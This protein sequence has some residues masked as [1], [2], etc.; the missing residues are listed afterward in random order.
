MSTRRKT[1]GEDVLGET[2]LADIADPYT[3][4]GVRARFSDL[5]IRYE[6]HS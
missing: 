5:S 3:D 4:T 2:I 1:P 6:R